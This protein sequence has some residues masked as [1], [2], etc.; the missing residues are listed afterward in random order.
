MVPGEGGDLSRN[1]RVVTRPIPIERRERNLSAETHPTWCARASCTAY[2]E[3]LE[4]LHRSEPVVIPADDDP[5][6]ALFI[7][8][9][10]DPDG[11]GECV[12]LVKLPTP[13]PEPWYLVEPVGMELLV[14]RSSAGATAHALS[15]MV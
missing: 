11:S 14:P 15:A 7:Y 13:A 12:A 1:R 9:M 5:G 4:P 6:V 2:Q 8:V 10:A 3:D